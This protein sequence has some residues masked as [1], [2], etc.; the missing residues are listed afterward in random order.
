MPSMRTL[1]VTSVNPFAKVAYQRECFNRWH[2]CGMRVVTCNT[3]LE[4]QRL[5]EQ[6]FSEQD[7]LAVPDAESGQALFGKPVPLIMPLLSA[8]ARNED[9]E[10]VILT[11]SDIYPAIRSGSIVDFWASHAQSLALSREDVYDLCAATFDASTPYRGGLDVFF[12]SLSALKK[13]ELMLAD[14]GSSERMAFGMPGWDYLLAAL[15]ISPEM[16]GKIL[17]SGVLLHRLHTPTYGNMNEFSHYVPDLQRM[18]A[19]KSTEPAVAAAEFAAAIEEQCRSNSG[20]SRFAKLIYFRR[21]ES[22]RGGE[23]HDASFEELWTYLASV[24]PF[25]EEL[26]RK[27]S[28]SSLYKRLVEDKDLGLDA[29]LSLFCTSQSAL[30]QFSQVLYSILFTLHARHSV[31]A[32]TFNSSYPSGNQHGAALRNI[33][34]NHDENDPLR[35]VWLAR[36][37][38]AELTGHGIFNPRIFQWLILSSESDLELNLVRAIEKFIRSKQKHVA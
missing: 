11:N 29:A 31:G 4:S 13:I 33:L 17:D 32:S 8:L 22:S 10:Y 7:I 21:P 25:F 34:A 15:I 38:G 20:V 37:F 6:G 1:V 5:V 12:F 30:F 14:N 36:L 16:G 3:Q 28:V 26:Y 2:S 24:A 23:E 18:G 35:R 27:Q 19:L 9:T